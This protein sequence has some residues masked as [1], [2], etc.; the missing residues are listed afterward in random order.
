MEFKENIKF[1]F[2]PSFEITEG[3]D[4]SGT[5]LQIG[6][7][8]LE[9]GVSRNNNKYTLKN[10]EENNGKQFKWLFGHPS[11]GSVEEHIVGMGK[12]TQENNKLFHEG[13]IRNTARHP[14][15]L[16]AVKDGFLGPSIHAT[17]DKV[18]REEGVYT[19]EGLEIDG[20]GLVAFQGVKNAS[21]DY[22]IAESF[23]KMESSV[24][25]DEK[26]SESE[27][28][29]KMSEEEIKQPEPEAQPQPAEEPQAEP[30]KEEEAP[31]QEDFTS[32]EVKSLREELNAIKLARKNDLVESIVSIN[33]DLKKEELMNESDEK[34][35]I[36][37]EY[38]MK[39][40]QKTESAAV[41][42]TEQHE[43][44]KVSFVEN[45]DG[46]YS[47]SKEMYENFNKEIRNKV[48]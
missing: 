16:E 22:A 33:K 17:A 44:E 5:W 28:E 41:V 29:L 4:T 25:E 10:L 32:E 1:S 38:E 46:S 35:K 30:A 6:G 8:A 3:K 37:L 39:L 14:D 9:E 27:G 15:V 24:A 18:S 43:E 45:K 31:A 34:L 42:E 11:D 21:I 20:V 48:R 23:D 40:S 13:K 26:K 47:M 7:L 2:T 12:L 36:V 19:V